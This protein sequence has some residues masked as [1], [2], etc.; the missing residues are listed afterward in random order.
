MARYEVLVCTSLPRAVNP[1]G[2]GGKVAGVWEEIGDES[3]GVCMLN[4]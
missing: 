4:L 1:L 3:P 2:P